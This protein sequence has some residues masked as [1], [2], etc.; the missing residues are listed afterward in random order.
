MRKEF[1][2]PSQFKE[3]AAVRNGRREPTI[4]FDRNNR[5]NTKMID[6]VV[7]QAA[8]RLAIN[9]EG[10][11]IYLWPSQQYPTQAWENPAF[12]GGHEMVGQ[13]VKHL[14]SS[15]VSHAV[16]LDDFNGRPSFAGE[17]DFLKQ[18]RRLYESSASIASSPIFDSE[19]HPQTQR[20]LESDF[21]IEGENNYCSTLDSAFQREKLLKLAGGDGENNFTDQQ[22]VDRLHD[23]QILMVHPASFKRQQSLMLTALLSEMKQSPFNSLT[24]NERRQLLSEIYRHIWLDDTTGQLEAVTQPIW[25][26]N[27]F[28]FKEVVDL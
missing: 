24:K 1:E 15:L 28:I 2:L 19:V 7:S 26:G 13:L 3:A 16:L 21:V 14:P 22:R 9:H 12:I 11:P 4:V 10:S 23:V 5:G 6:Y 27:K 20:Y 25:D 8:S 18:L 17:D